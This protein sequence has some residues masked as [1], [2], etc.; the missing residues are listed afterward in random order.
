M[1]NIIKNL[2]LAFLLV[3]Q[4]SCE[5]DK[6]PV[7]AANG[8][9]LRKDATIVSPTILIE[10]DNAVVFGKYNW[11]ISNNGVATVSTY[12]L[13]IFDHD[14]DIQQLY[15]VEYT[16]QGLDVTPELREGEITVKEMNDMINKLPTFKCG[17][18]NI[19]VRIQSTIGSNPANA[20][21]Q[22]SSPINVK[23]T[24]YSTQKLILS[25]VKDGESANVANQPKL[26]T[27]SF[28]SLTDYE[29]YTYLQPGS[30]KFYRPDACGSYTNATVL[31]GTGTLAVGVIDVTGASNIVIPTAGHYQIKANLTANTF[32]IRE[33]KAFGIYGTA[34]RS[35]AI[36]FG[37]PMI[38]NNDNKWSIT[39]DLFKGRKFK[40]KA[41]SLNTSNP[42]LIPTGVSVLA[43][44]G[45]SSVAGELSDAD[46]DFL[47]GS[48]QI[49][50]PG[51]DDGTKVSCIIKVDISNPRKYTY[52]LTTL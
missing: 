24:A 22:Y 49:V 47:T 14:S 46:P 6:D 41:G 13:V 19:D 16:G 38:D 35:S 36:G 48:N 17:E 15:P 34:V 37:T 50:V 23:V 33:Y 9:E 25:L 27:S 42:P 21:I 51:S 1:K 20:L 40:F 4:I 39:I 29:G 26:L 31:G 3:S 12:K 28:N 52:K 30:Y 44:F 18:M 43:A 32:S 8:F 10:T 7:V 11:D 2:I 5:N 45:K